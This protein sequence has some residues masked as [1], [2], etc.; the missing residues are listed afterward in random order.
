[1]SFQLAHI[2]LS[3]W[4]IYVFT[5]CQSRKPV[6]A[7]VGGVYL[8]LLHAQSARMHTFQDQVMIRTQPML[9]SFNTECVPTSV[10]NHCDAE[11]GAS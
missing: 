6:S 8:P 1:M 10:S 4:R 7:G 11:R 5:E 2:M 3:A 9:V